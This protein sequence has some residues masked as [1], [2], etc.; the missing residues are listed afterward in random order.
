MVQVGQDLE[1][2]DFMHL[3]YESL[4]LDT[5]G[6]MAKLIIRGLVLLEPLT[7]HYPDVYLLSRLAPRLFLFITNFVATFMFVSLLAYGSNNNC[8]TFTHFYI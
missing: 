1:Y 5:V 4:M 6:S 3:A 2:R 7:S 8:C